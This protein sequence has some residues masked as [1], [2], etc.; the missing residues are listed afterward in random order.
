[1]KGKTQKFQYLQTDG[2]A[3]IIDIDGDEFAECDYG[4]MI[5]NADNIDAFLQKFNSYAQAMIQNQTITLSTLLKV[6]NGSSIADV[7]RSVE[8]DERQ[9][10]EAKQKEMQQ[11]QQQVQAQLQQQA[12]QVEHEAQLK[13]LLNQRDNETKLQVAQIQAAVQQEAQDAAREEYN[14]QLQQELGEKIRQF[15]MTYG[16]KDKKLELDRQKIEADKKIKQQQVNIQRIQANKPTNNGN[17]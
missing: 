8:D 10:K 15:N 13:D 5:D 12:A 9:A 17:R 2:T 1:M 7:T 16:L 4:L 3:K 6:W 14:P 11:Q